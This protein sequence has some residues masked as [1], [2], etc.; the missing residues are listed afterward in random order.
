MRGAT[1]VGREAWPAA[2]RASSQF[3][4]NAR[5]LL[6]VIVVAVVRG[7][8]VEAA[9]AVPGGTGTTAALAAGKTVLL[10]APSRAWVAA[11]PLREQGMH[12]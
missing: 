3:S 5:G 8:E 2:R 7:A 4:S 10:D 6:S 1:A 12:T 9:V 11:V